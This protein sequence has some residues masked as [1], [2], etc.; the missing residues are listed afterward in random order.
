MGII[1][2]KSQFNI[3]QICNFLGEAAFIIDNKF[4]LVYANK[5]F[6]KLMGKKDLGKKCYEFVHGLNKPIKNCPFKISLKTKK[7]QKQEIFHKHSNKWFLITANPFIKKGKIDFWVIFLKD[8]TKLKEDKINLKLEREKSEKFLKIIKSII[9]HLN[10]KG[11]IIFVNKK[12]CQVLNWKKKELLGK[13]WF[14]TCLPK[15]TRNKVKKVFLDLIN[16]KVKTRKYFKNPIITKKGKV[17]MIKWHNT[18]LRD[19][20]KIIGTL[21][22]GE[23][24]T[25]EEEI[26]K[27]LEK[28]F[29]EKTKELKQSKEHLNK[30]ILSSPSSIV[31][32]DLQGNIL[33]LN[34]ETLKLHGFKN[35]KELIGKNSLSLIEES[36]H[37]KAIKNLKRT[38]NKGFIKATEYI[39]KRK[40]GSTFYGELSASL[41]K[42]SS[43]KPQGFIAI[44]QDITKRKKSEKIIKNE[45]KKLNEINQAKNNFLDTISHELKTPLTSINAHLQLLEENKN[46]L[47]KED[48]ESLEII[49]I[50]NEQLKFLIDN[51][52]EISRIKSKRLELFKSKVNINSLIEEVV[53]NLK[54]LSIKKTIKMITQIP[55]NTFV[56]G[57][58]ER[59]KEIFNNLINNAIK[60]TKKGSI[61][62]KAHKIRRFINFEILDTGIGIS[63]N[64]LTKIFGKF[65]Q[66]KT[67]LNKKYDG[68][69]LGLE[70]SKQLVELHGGKIKV[71]SKLG[72]GTI[73]TFT[74]PIKKEAKI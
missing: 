17:K 57:D 66:L 38:L 4:N 34:K 22:S 68:T 47:N 33:N 42:N 40:D 28:K 55:P 7:P 69:G 63:K 56:Y 11:K 2:E 1:F 9:I 29:E 21:S 13:D 43:G 19:N 14:K 5:R 64:D 72:K 37:K 39:L 44:T 18:I 58:K 65:F 73:F 24:I 8:I 62:I 23:N 52:L 59:I 30:V 45:V 25:K 41:I 51:I 26:K 71:E 15:K 12:A 32:T 10:S 74:L 46:L 60:F 31:V 36:E 16:G 61:T 48:K 49:L 70:I 20:G 35:K 67:N 54:Y 50:N 53:K 3:K 6:I 27:E